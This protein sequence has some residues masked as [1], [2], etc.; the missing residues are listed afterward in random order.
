M[1]SPRL[2]ILQPP[3]LRTPRE[4]VYTS[5]YLRYKGLRLVVKRSRIRRRFRVGRFPRK[6]FRPSRPV[7]SFVSPFFFGLESERSGRPCHAQEDLRWEG[8]C[9][10]EI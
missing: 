10:V 7:G 9:I 3:T 4:A 1:V 5:L 2:T 8:N 6:P